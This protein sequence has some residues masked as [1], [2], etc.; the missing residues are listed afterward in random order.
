MMVLENPISQEKDIYVKIMERRLN[1]Q[2]EEIKRREEIIERLE[3]ELLKIRRNK[4]VDHIC[5]NCSQPCVKK[6]EKEKY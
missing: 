3:A 5:E 1:L 4:H 2:Q 6:E